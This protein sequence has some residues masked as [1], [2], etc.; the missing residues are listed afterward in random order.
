[1]QVRLKKQQFSIAAQFSFQKKKIWILNAIP[2]LQEVGKL[3]QDM[4]QRYLLMYASVSTV[5]TFILRKQLSLCHFCKMKP[6]IKKKKSL[7]MKW[8]PICISIAY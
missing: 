1:M 5:W 6:M 2:L 7:K 8:K 4:W 3:L